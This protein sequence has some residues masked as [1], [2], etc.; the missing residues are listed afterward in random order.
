MDEA[1][2]SLSES[3][4]TDLKLQGSIIARQ[5]SDIAKLTED[6]RTAMGNLIAR[7]LDLAEARREAEALRKGLRRLLRDLD[8]AGI[9]K[10]FDMAVFRDL[11]DSLNEAALL[12][13]EE[14]GEKKC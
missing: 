14:K 2:N 4:N 9:T 5:R 3:H 6:Y 10:A 12:V 7:K 1:F 11:N 8:R 13:Q